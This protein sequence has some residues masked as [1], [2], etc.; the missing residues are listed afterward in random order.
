MF[1]SM[2]SIAFA[3]AVAFFIVSC[4]GSTA[5]APRSSGAAGMSTSDDA[6][7]T[8]RVKTVLLNDTQVNATRIDVTTSN[9]VVTMSGVVKSKAEE[10]R[11]IQLARQ[12]S[13]VRDVKSTLTIPQL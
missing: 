7:I 12:V 8:A 2:I 10:E 6:T 9:G 3:L 11:A 1:R 4:G 5:S 13:G